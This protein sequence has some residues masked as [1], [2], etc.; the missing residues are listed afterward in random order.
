MGYPQ[1]PGGGGAYH[2][3]QQPLPVSSQKLKV[4]MSRLGVWPRPEIDF[5]DPNSLKPLPQLPSN[6]FFNVGLIQNWSSSLE[7]INKQVLIK[8]Y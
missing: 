1:V 5:P 7:T 8:I 6:D 4:P 2:Y 3:E